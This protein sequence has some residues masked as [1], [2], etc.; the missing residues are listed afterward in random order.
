MGNLN[1]TFSGLPSTGKTTLLQK[2][3]ELPKYNN[4]YTPPSIGRTLKETGIPINEY[5]N[6][7]TQVGAFSLHLLYLGQSGDQGFL[8][9][10]NLLDAWVFTLLD[11][12]ITDQQKQVFSEF[13]HFNLIKRPIYDK[14]IYLPPIAVYEDDG[15]RTKNKDFLQKLEITYKQVISDLQLNTY[16]DMFHIVKS[17]G[18]NERLEEVL[19]FLEV[20]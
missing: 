7:E 2:I 19:S 16:S 1:I 10:R 20:N 12:N 6:L 14:I 3:K 11:D 17:Y 18:Q 15:V 4:Y 9:E 5:G 13:V 8:H